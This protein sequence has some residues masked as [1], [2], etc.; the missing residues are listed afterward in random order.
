VGEGSADD[1]GAD[2][3]DVVG[4]GFWGGG[5]VSVESSAVPVHDDDG[6]GGGDMLAISACA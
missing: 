4:A 1:A 2:D 6:G 5:G 3:G